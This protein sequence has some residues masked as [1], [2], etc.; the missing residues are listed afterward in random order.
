MSGFVTWSTKGDW[1]GFIIG[2]GSCFT[3]FYILW[4]F[5]Y[6]KISGTILQ[7][8]K[9]VF[10]NIIIPSMFLIIILL[11]WMDKDNAFMDKITIKLVEVGTGI[12]NALISIVQTFY[13]L[14]RY[15]YSLT[16]IIAI[17]VFLVFFAVYDF[18]KKTRPLFYEHN[19]VKKE[20]I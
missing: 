1:T 11:G 9:S 19:G 5:D 15:E 20:I 17:F 12:S 14:G 4:R 6:A 13:N 8:I 10:F 18:L 2:V 16:F 7:L 3:V